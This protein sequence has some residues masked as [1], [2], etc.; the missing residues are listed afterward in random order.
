[1]AA[2]RL[3]SLRAHRRPNPQQ[4]IFVRH[5]QDSNLRGGGIDPVDF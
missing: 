4:N 5:W 1:L 2:E 3:V